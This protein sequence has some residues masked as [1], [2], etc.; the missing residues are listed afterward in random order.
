MIRLSLL[1]FVVLGL[2]V[3]AWKDWYKSLCGLV[4]LMDFIERP[5]VP[6]TLFG[7]QGLNLWNLVFLNVLMSWAASRRAEGLVWD[8]PRHVTVL[9]LLYLAIVV[10]GFGRMIADRDLLPQSAGALWAEHLINTVK[11]VIPGLLL[12]HGCRSPRRLRLAVASVLVMYLL[13]GLQVIREMPSALT[14]SGD[15]LQQ[16]ALKVLDRQIGYHRVNLSMMLAGA[17]WA[18]YAARPLLARSGGRGLI[19]GAAITTAFAGELHG[20]RMGYG[21]WAVVGL[22]MGL[23]RWRG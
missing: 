20:G 15:R 16:R 3:Y 10:T 5:E 12:F 8:M 11:W 2:S 9:L 7:V 22:V 1:W 4:L 21:T 17:S 13:I 23:L 19:T 18:I 14:M 6:R